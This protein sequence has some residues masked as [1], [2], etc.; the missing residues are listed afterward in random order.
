M[1]SLPPVLECGGNAKAW[2][3]LMQHITGANVAQ[4][5]LVHGPVGCG[6]FFGVH[7]LL[8]AMG[9][10]VIVIDASEKLVDVVHTL[11]TQFAARTFLTKYAVVIPGINGFQKEIID[12]IP[13]EVDALLTSKRSSTTPIIATCVDPWDLTVV[14]LRQWKRCVT[15]T[16]YEDQIARCMA[17][18]HP[19]ASHTV[20]TR[21]AKLCRG[22]LRECERIIT[23]PQCGMSKKDVESNIYKKTGDLLQKKIPPGAWVRSAVDHDVSTFGSHPMLLHHNYP[24]FAVAHAARDDPDAAVADLERVARIADAISLAETSPRFQLDTL[25]RTV[26]GTCMR[27]FRFQFPSRRSTAPGTASR[28]GKDRAMLPGALRDRLSAT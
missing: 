4:P 2:R 22:D 14:P 1:T 27:D 21:A 16:P 20:V 15:Y 6:K 25:A 17:H 8:E 12:A 9:A 10:S 23:I 7:T 11:R 28:E 19:D 13:R 18:K 24:H 3:L 5:I 26:Y